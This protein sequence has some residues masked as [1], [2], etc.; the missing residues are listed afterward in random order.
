MFISQL[1]SRLGIEFINQI[2]VLITLPIIAN[3]LGLNSFA[4]IS[5][6]LIIMN[7]I[8]LIS[9]WG[10]DASSIEILN[11]KIQKKETEIYLSSVFIIRFSLS[12]LCFIFLYLIIFLNI[13]KFDFILLLYIFIPII[14]TNLIPLWY[15]QAIGKSEKLLIPTILGRVLFVF[16]IIY[17]V[18]N[19]ENIIWVFISHGISSIVVSVCGLYIIFNKYKFVIPSFEK[20]F[21]Y[22]KSSSSHFLLILM[23]NHFSSLWSFI[24]L[25]YGSST[26]IAYYNLANYFLKAG[27][28]I[29]EMISRIIKINSYKEFF[30]KTK[31]ISLLVASTY[32][33]I[34]CV[35][36][37]LIEDIIIIFFND[38]YRLSANIFKIMIL[39]WFLNALYKIINYNFFSKILT[40]EKTNIIS[41]KIG[42]IHVLLI[43]LW[44]F[45]EDFQSIF[46]LTI[47]MLLSC[48]LQLIMIMIYIKIY[49]KNR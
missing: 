47:F 18:K 31:Q 45:I 10:V 6:G 44:V 30:Y 2:S 33:I 11:K 23:N 8:L 13:Y 19:Q 7:I 17:F 41:I 16:I 43:I 12:F 28:G 27:M 1:K 42:F 38:S 46:S 15:F 37:I 25:I 5:Q 36:V 14:F 9:S 34:S 26:G 3:N 22:F 48:V 39:I 4:Y 40:E 20:I 35:G 21:T 32:L 29:S 49:K 24:I